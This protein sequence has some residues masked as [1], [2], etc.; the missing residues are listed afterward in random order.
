MASYQRDMGDIRPMSDHLRESPSALRRTRRRVSVLV[1]DDDADTRDLLAMTL[2]RRGYSVV[3]SSN[4]SDAL[5]VLRSTE[6][7]MILLDIQMPVMD[8]AEF[9]QAQRRDS[10]LI[11][12]PTIVMTGSREEPV[13]DIGVMET[14]AKP[15]TREE[16]LALVERHCVPPSV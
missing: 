13:L 1:V 12:I 14:L 9:R 4:G 7:E 15:F 10:R 16:L 11:R 6:P 2:L 8:G 3:T 5:D